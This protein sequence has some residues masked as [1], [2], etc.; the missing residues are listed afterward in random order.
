MVVAVGNE[1]KPQQ[2]QTRKNSRTYFLIVVST[3]KG[4]LLRQIIVRFYWRN[5]LLQIM[6]L[7]EVFSP[8]P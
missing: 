6:L 7:V 1:K 2:I 5:F 8:T 3:I 4:R